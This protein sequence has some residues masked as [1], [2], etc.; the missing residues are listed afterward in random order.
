MYGW[1]LR[2]P[3]ISFD[4]SAL[5][6]AP[7]REAGRPSALRLLRPDQ[8][9][10][11]Y[12]LASKYTQAFLA[13]SDLVASPPTAFY[14]IPRAAGGRGRPPAG[15]NRTESPAFN[16]STISDLRAGRAHIAIRPALSK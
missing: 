7:Q 3:T 1:V 10:T 5:L 12:N 16:P 14:L 8:R 4:G 11:T 13:P 9:D 15:N 2:T 6:L